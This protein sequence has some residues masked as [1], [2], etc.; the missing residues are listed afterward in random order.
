MPKFK[1]KHPIRKEH[2]AAEEKGESFSEKAKAKFPFLRH[3]KWLD[4]FTYVDLWVMPRVKKVTDSGAVETVVNVVFAFLFA[5]I[6]Y[7]ALGILFGSATPLVIVYSASMENTFFRGDVMALSAASQSAFFGP[8]ISLDREIRGVPASSF[9]TPNY[10][11]GR[12]ESLLFSNGAEVKYEKTGSVIV[13]PAY[14]SGLPIIHRTIAKINAKDG[15]FFITKGDNDS[16]NP[17]FDQDCGAVDEL[18]LA[19]EKPCITFHAVPAGSIQ[20]VAFFTIP[21]AGCLKLW[22]L[23]DL[24]SIVSTGSLPSDFRGIC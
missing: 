5:W 20:G 18:R 11:D 8:E 19:S 15:V 9:I 16:T 1:L 2:L 4:P 13:Y 22:L 24:L 23:D 3:L 6:F 7:T 17:T 21:K 14:P 12:L 10:S